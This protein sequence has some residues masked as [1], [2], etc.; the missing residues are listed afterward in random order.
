MGG[1]KQG[2]FVILRFPLFGSVWGS[3]VTQMLGKTARKVSLSH[4]FCV[5]QMIVKTRT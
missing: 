1:V 2:R 5:P 4:P 3:R